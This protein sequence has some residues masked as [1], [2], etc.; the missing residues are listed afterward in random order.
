MLRAMLADRFKLVVHAETK[1]QPIYALVLARADGRLGP[2]MKPSTVD[3]TPPTTPERGPQTSA[4]GTNT[5]VS[6]NSGTLKGTGRLLADIAETLGNFVADRMVIDR[7]GLTG[8]FDIELKWTPDNLAAGP[9]A[10]G[11]ATVPD[12]ASVFTAIQE[13]LGL[14]LEPQRGAV[15][16]LVID[17]IEQPT[18]D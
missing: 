15:E 18:P 11:T 14:K 3:C 13:Q 2:Q 6:N 9:A 7:T 10:T 5:S 12:G 16:F 1:E 8:R 17:S 4:C